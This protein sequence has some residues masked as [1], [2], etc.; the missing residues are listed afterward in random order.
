[1]HNACSIVQWQTHVSIA[2]GL[3]FDPLDDVFQCFFFLSCRFSISILFELKIMKA[4]SSWIQNHV[5]N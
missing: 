5:Y 2:L 4:K 1:M 3:G